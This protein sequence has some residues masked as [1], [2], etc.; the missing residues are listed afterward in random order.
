MPGRY[1]EALMHELWPPSGNSRTGVWAI[2]D[3]ARDEHVVRTVTGSSLEHACLYRGNL[4]QAL[5]LAAPWL[6]ELQRAIPST[7]RLLDL[8]WGNSWGVILKVDDS[9][10]LHRH[11]RGFLRV[12]SERGK[13]MVF[14]YYD[15]RVLRTYLPTCRPTELRT[16]FGPIRSFVMED[17][18]PRI[19][20]QFA[21]DGH[22]LLERRVTL[23][24]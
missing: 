2:L 20:L 11:L 13:S 21:F 14:R 7:G 19:L 22:R 9:V 5:R 10:G 8:A 1:R 24:P 4:P 17:E 3:G 15:P 6:V 18:D 12:K 23:G 16:I